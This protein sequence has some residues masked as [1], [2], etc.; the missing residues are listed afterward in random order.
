LPTDRWQVNELKKDDWDQY[1]A[2]LH[3]EIVEG[4]Q[5]SNE[6]TVS[7]EA[8]QQDGSIE[9][10]EPDG[11]G[12]DDG[13]VQFVC[14]SRWKQFAHCAFGLL[15]GT[16]S[17]ALLREPWNEP[18][19]WVSVVCVLGILPLYFGVLTASAV[20]I[21]ELVGGI[22]F[23]MLSV[24]AGLNAMFYVMAGSLD[25]DLLLSPMVAYFAFVTVFVGIFAVV[26]K[27][28][29][30]DA[31]DPGVTATEDSHDSEFGTQ[32]RAVTT[33]DAKDEEK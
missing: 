18:I 9:C 28:L 32:R 30:R 23:V 14:D 4:K 19:H 17:A 26:K 3:R 5:R 11:G 7:T 8:N 6:M 22:T 24:W 20:R 25:E 29:R 2:W 1:C 13:A 10:N 16:N 33:K 27:R 15:L 31:G 12:P 21:R